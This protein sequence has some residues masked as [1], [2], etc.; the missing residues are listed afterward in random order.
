[1][2]LAA[3][4]SLTGLQREALADWIAATPEAVPLVVRVLHAAGNSGID[5]TL[6]ALG[7]ALGRVYQEPAQRGREELIVMA[8]DGLTDEHIEVLASSSTQR[9]TPQQ[10]AEKLVDRVAPELIS[11]ALASMMPRGLYDNPYGG[12]GGGEAWA[13]GALGVAVRDAAVTAHPQRLGD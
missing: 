4:E 1:M 12:Y 5:R 2:A 10:L 8:L 6:R 13:L 9:Q 11:M 7:E 3:A